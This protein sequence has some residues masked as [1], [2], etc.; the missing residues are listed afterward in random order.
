MTSSELSRILQFFTDS[1]FCRRSSLISSLFDPLH[2]PLLDYIWVWIFILHF[3]PA[4]IHF[5]LWD[6]FFLN[7]F[8]LHFFHQLEMYSLCYICEYC[9]IVMDS[10]ELVRLFPL[11]LMMCKLTLADLEKSSYVAKQNRTISNGTINNILGI[12]WPIPSFALSIFLYLEK[13]ALFHTL[14]K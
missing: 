1:A 2:I 13:Q 10:C 9:G 8:Y 12:L 11:F 14:H 7:N 6:F 3:R 4:H 5:P